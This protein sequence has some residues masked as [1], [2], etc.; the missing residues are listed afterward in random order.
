MRRAY[1]DSW[2]DLPMGRARVIAALLVVCPAIARGD[3]TEIHVESTDITVYAD[4]VWAKVEDDATWESWVRQ[5]GDVR[6]Q[7]AVSFSSAISGGCPSDVETLGDFGLEGGTQVYDL[8]TTGT[9]TSDSQLFATCTEIEGMAYG[10]RIELPYGA[11]LRDDWYYSIVSVAWS[12][13]HE[14]VARAA[15]AA[16]EPDDDESVPASE[17]SDVTLWAPPPPPP[18]K[19]IWPHTLAAGFVKRTDD[20]SEGAWGGGAIVTRRPWHV[21]RHLALGYEASITAAGGWF[22]GAALVRPGVWAGTDAQTRAEFHK[23]LLLDAYLALG[24]DA[25]TGSDAPATGAAVTF[26]GG[27]AATLLFQGSSEIG[28]GLD[29]GLQLLADPSGFHSDTEEVALLVGKETRR[30]IRV[31][32]RHVGDDATG[33]VWWL[34]FGFI[35]ARNDR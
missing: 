8:G 21:E 22:S 17:W 14:L 7:G 4:D 19:W 12:Y 1:R 15:P 30:L 11:D 33:S 10:V 6:K 2:Q 24:V 28:V 25:T 9:W 27:L 18:R 26:G 5:T 13:I 20:S 23:G 34:T 32:F 3:S 29:L 35:D 16:V 31:G